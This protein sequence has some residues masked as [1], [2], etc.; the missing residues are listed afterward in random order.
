MIGVLA[1]VV[2][3]S[4]IVV[5]GAIDMSQRGFDQVRSF[6]RSL[7]RSLVHS[8]VRPFVRSL[9][10]SFVGG[11]FVERAEKCAC[12]WWVVTIGAS[13]HAHTLFVGV[14]GAR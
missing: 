7:V 9:V 3:S 8:R 13:T 4:A 1:P 12:R 11:C 6:V 5:L 14:A 10:R 2:M